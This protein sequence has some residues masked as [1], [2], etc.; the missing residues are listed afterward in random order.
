MDDREFQD[1]RRKVVDLDNRLKRVAYQLD[2]CCKELRELKEDMTDKAHKAD[3][4]PFSSENFHV[5]T[6]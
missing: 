5:G 4:K 6:I 2:K 3:K 1:L